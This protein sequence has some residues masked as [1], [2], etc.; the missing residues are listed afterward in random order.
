[1]NG[2]SNMSLELNIQWIN[3]NTIIYKLS[4]VQLSKLSSIY[5]FWQ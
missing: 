3:L 4:F 1:V 2:V 5:T